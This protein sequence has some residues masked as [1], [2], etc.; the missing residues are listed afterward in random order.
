MNEQILLVEDDAPLRSALAETLSLADYDVLEAADGKAAL[1]I[2]ESCDVDAVVSD[3]Q[4]QPM[5]G[6]ELLSRLRHTKPSLPFVLMTAYGSIQHAIESIR[7]GAS[8]YLVKPFDAPTL[9][10]KLAEVIT[11]QQP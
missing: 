2:L 1:E 9:I 3:Y 8:D 11:Q 5:N 10:D 4:M 7:D 6:S